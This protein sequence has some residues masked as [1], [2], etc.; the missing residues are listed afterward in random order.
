MANLVLL[1]NIDH[2]DLRLNRRRGAGNGE[3]VNQVRVFPTEFQAL[4]RDYPLFFRRADDGAF[5]TV[6]ILGLDRDENLYLEDRDGE[7]AW[8]AR[9][10]PAILDR[11]PFSIGTGQAAD[12]QSH[13]IMVDLDHPWIGRETGEPLFRSHGGNGPLL[14]RAAETLRQLHSGVALE[15]AM[16]DAFQ[17]A[18]L[19]A[20]LELTVRLDDS[21]EYKLPELYTIRP[22]ALRDLDGASLQ[23]LNRN[24]F[25]ELATY[26]MASHANLNR[27]T[28]VKNER[29][30]I[31]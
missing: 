9:T 28:Q 14:D 23:A 18:D 26:V 20:Y 21:T 12:G 3:T 27:L 15:A 11:G 22:D 17:A 16:F 29:R 31:L 25:L 4:Q 13:M 24:G 19:L 1:N 8:T 5:Y 2:H 7:P 30:G 10:V 6:A